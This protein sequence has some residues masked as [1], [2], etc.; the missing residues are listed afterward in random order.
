MSSARK[1]S[2]F[3]ERRGG[4]RRCLT[5][6]KT[7]VSVMSGQ[8]AAVAVEAPALGER[9]ADERLSAADV[10][11]QRRGDHDGRT[12]VGE[13]LGEAVG[14]LRDDDRAAPSAAVASVT[15]FRN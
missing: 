2:R 1:A 3:S 4:A 11:T 15:S 9:A 8:V 5:K 12:L 13:D 14:L 6:P 10:S 7:S